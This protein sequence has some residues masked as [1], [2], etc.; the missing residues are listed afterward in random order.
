MSG[1]TTNDSCNLIRDDFKARNIPEYYHDVYRKLREKKFNLKIT[2]SLLRDALQK[3]LVDEPELMAQVLKDTAIQTAIDSGT[4]EERLR[5]TRRQAD[6][7]HTEEE[8]DWYAKTLSARKNDYERILQTVQE[9]QD[10]LAA[11]KQELWDALSDMETAE[12][13]DRYRAY[14]AYKLQFQDKLRS[15][16]NNSMFIA[17]SAALLAGC[18]ITLNKEAKQDD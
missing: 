7:N 8:L 11:E 16:Q 15:P 1:N 6:L 3:M 9:E 17:G 5:Q 13:R 18:P 12:M 4:K 14:M 2:G 10:K